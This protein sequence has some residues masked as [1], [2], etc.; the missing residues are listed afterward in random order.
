MGASNSL[1]D[2]ARIYILRCAQR[3][4]NCKFQRGLVFKFNWKLCCVDIPAVQNGSF[5]RRIL[6]TNPSSP[7]R[8]PRRHSKVTPFPSLPRPHRCVRFRRNYFAGEYCIFPGI[9]LLRCN[10]TRAIRAAE[11]WNKSEAVAR[12]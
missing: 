6:S 9:L 3:S 11:I 2:L 8:G 12:H 5:P 7:I 4:L 1:S 10:A